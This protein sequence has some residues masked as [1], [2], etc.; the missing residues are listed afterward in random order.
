LVR[1]KTWSFPTSQP[2]DIRCNAGAYRSRD[3]FRKSRKS[4]SVSRLQTAAGSLRVPP[5]ADITEHDRDVCFVPISDKVD[6]SKKELFNHLLGD[7]PKPRDITPLADHVRFSNR[8]V[9]VKRFQTH[10]DCGVDVT[11]GLALLFGIGA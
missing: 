6:Y 2:A 5:K 3:L 11:C 4:W 8:P 1:S 7:Y 9:E 10:H